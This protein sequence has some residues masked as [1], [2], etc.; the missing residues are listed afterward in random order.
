VDSSCPTGFELVKD[1]ECRGKIGHYSFFYD[2]AFDAAVANCSTIQG[3]IPVIHDDELVKCNMSLTQRLF[4]IG[5]VCNTRS[6]RWEW[7]DGSALDYK[8]PSGGYQKGG[9]I[10]GK[11]KDGFGWIDGT[12]WDYTNFFP[13]FPIDG[14]G[15]CLSMD[16]FGSSGQWMNMDC[17]SK[18][19]VACVRNQNVS[20]PDVCSSG[21]WAEGQIIYTPGYPY[22]S[23]VPCDFFFTVEAGKKVEVK[24]HLLEANNCCDHL[25]LSDNYLGGNVVA[26]LTGYLTG[27]T[28]TTK[29]SNLMRVSWNPNSGVNVRGAMV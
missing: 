2:E 16:T 9:T 21:P 17:D 5:L 22:D 12:E 27:M 20:N 26:N 11:G 10:S 18:L 24:V 28:Y 7:I 29:S 14:M 13:G 3:Q 6:K 4:C 1:G 8:P 25:L 23:S 19:A 15:D